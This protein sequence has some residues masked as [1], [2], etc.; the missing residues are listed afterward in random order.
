[1]NIDEALCAFKDMLLY[2]KG[3]LKDVT[4]DSDFLKKLE[5]KQQLKRKV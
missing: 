4:A 2:F 3:V 5:D 1:M